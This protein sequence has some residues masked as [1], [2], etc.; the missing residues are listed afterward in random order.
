MKKLNNYIVLILFFIVSNAFT[1]NSTALIRGSVYEEGVPLPGATIMIKNTQIGAVTDFDGYFE[2][3]NVKSGTY[4]LLITLIG[5]EVKSLSIEV[6]ISGELNLGIIN[7]KPSAE[8]LNEVV[9]TAL[10]MKREKKALGYSVGEVDS[11]KV[12]LVPQE[13]VMS[14]LSSKISGLDIRRSGN[15]LNAET[16]VYIRGRTSLTGNDEPNNYIKDFLPK[17]LST[18]AL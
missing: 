5:Y 11:E 3:K 6:P 18:K 16:H 4:Q 13:N 17:W 15:D 12:N 2:I 7:L 9:I 10:G 1:Q 14:S 8:S